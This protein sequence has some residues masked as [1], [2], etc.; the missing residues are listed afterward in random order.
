MV[1]TMVIGYAYNSID[2]KVWSAIQNGPFE[3]TMTNV[4]E[5]GV[6]KPE[7]QRDVE[8]EKK[9]SSDWKVRNIII[10]ALRFDEYYRVSHCET[11]KATLDALQVA[12]EGTNKVKQDRVKTLNSFT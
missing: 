1:R 8:D 7:A 5:V 12:H 10:S 3:I 6:P 4:N 2:I 9:W 11:A